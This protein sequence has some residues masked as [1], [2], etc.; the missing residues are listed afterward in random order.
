MSDTDTIDVQKH[1]AVTT[2]IWATRLADTINLDRYDA[3]LTMFR[4]LVADIAVAT[5]EL[6]LIANAVTN[7]KEINHGIY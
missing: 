4:E 7:D 1:K 2:I 3:N 5:N 6:I